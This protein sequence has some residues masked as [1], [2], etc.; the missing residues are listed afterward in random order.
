MEILTI[1]HAPHCT[2]LFSLSPSPSPSPSSVSSRYLT[3]HQG[4]AFA[5]WER[6][7]GDF[8]V[9][10]D[11][12]TLRVAAWLDK[13]AVVIADAAYETGVEVNKSHSPSSSSSSSSSA[14][15]AASSSDGHDLVAVS[16]R[17]ILLQQLSRAKSLGFGVL[18]ATELEFYLFETGY[19]EA[20]KL[21]YR[22]GSLVS[23]SDYVE[24]YHTLQGAREERFNQAFRRYLRKSGV[25][26]EC[27][28]SE[29]GVGQ[30]ELNVLYSDAL[31]AADRHAVYKMCLKETADK[32][33]GSVTFM[34]KPYEDA[35]GSGCHIH[36]NLIHDGPDGGNAFKG[37]E[38]I[39]DAGRAASITCSPL[40][41][42]V[43]CDV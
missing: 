31:T 27:S 2:S 32:L 12:S 16:P 34:A 29:A 25:P 36:I 33:G 13:T 28:K 24:D 9:C 39:A 22:K 8:H 38:K 26:V 7:Y 40:F 14:S 17:T 23:S 5:N 35:T 43:D 19:R 3:L 10:P 1:L 6:G 18:A 41:K 20:R 21:D 30:Q 4:F 37:T 42:Y 11:L 15:S